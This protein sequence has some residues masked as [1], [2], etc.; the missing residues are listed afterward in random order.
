MNA[1]KAKINVYTPSELGIGQR[2]LRDSLEQTRRKHKHDAEDC[3]VGG[4]DLC[5]L[6]TFSPTVARLTTTLFSIPPA[7]TYRCCQTSLASGRSPWENPGAGC[8]HALIQCQCL[9]A[10]GNFCAWSST[11]T[12]G[13]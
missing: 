2:G 9:S 6:P 4:N 12:L 1:T 7:F 3:Q 11:V 10:D 8:G 5:D 13:S